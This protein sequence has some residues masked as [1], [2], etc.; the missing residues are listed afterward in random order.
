MLALILVKIQ[1]SVTSFTEVVVSSIFMT[2]LIVIFSN[3]SFCFLMAI[4]HIITLEACIV[5][6]ITL[7]LEQT[8][9]CSPHPCGWLKQD[10]KNGM[11]EEGILLPLIF[12]VFLFI[13]LI[14][15]KYS[16]PHYFVYILKYI[17]RF[18]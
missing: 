8:L 7:I 6:S 17:S 18:F 2:D 15:M 3:L 1:I 16:V 5:S 11:F 9:P 13:L 12:T 14:L 4:P 10:S